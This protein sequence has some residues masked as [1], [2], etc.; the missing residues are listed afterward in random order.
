M[1]VLLRRSAFAGVIAAVLAMAMTLPA[2]SQI[3]GLD[4]LP[5]APPGVIGAIL[6]PLEDVIETITDP[7]GDALGDVPFDNAVRLDANDA[8]EASIALSRITFD[9][10][11]LVMIGRDDVFADSLSSVAS[12]GIAG[13]PLLLTQTD[14]L[15]LRIADELTRLGATE[16]LL[17]GSEDAISPDLESKFVANFGEDNVSRVGGPSRVETAAMLAEHVAPNA[18]TALLMRA[19]PDEGTDQS[20]AYAD[21]LGAGPLG[22]SMEYPALLTTTGYLHPAAEAYFEDSGVEE[23]VIVGGEAA[24]APEVADT[25]TDMGITVTRVAGENRYGTAIEIARFMGFLDAADTSRLILTEAGSVEEP[26]W[27]AGFSAAAHGAV[28]EA[29]VILADGPL[30]PPETIAYLG[31]GLLSNALRLNNLP[32][33]CNSFVDFLACETAALLMLGLLD[34]VNELTGGVL[35]DVLGPVFDQLLD[36]LEGIIP[37]SDGTSPGLLGAILSIIGVDGD[38]E[39]PAGEDGTD[40]DGDGN[41]DDSDADCPDDQS[42]AFASAMAAQPTEVRAAFERVIGTEGNRVST[43]RQ[44]ALIPI[45][46]NLADTLGGP[47]D[48]SDPVRAAA[49]V[50]ILDAIADVLGSQSR[51]VPLDQLN[52]LLTGVET[53][54]D[55]LVEDSAL[56]SLGDLVDILDIDSS[57]TV[58]GLVTEVTGILGGLSGFDSSTRSFT[59]RYGDEAAALEQT[60][61]RLTA[62]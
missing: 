18:D 49:L 4:D 12:Q 44:A 31:D 57:D 28:Y 60:L 47:V 61:E 25:L 10:A 20:Q 27:S 9:S 54:L 34:E 38:E 7:L 62:Q 22:S 56:G 1:S 30:L 46:E 33:I 36:L 55:G 37:G 19:Y 2:Q 15:D 5:V 14:D 40:C 45:F 58:T 51:V 41:T 3:P 6:D 43:S 52:D 39:T 26:L 8:V 17:L 23:V 42:A 24:I 29:P 50:A 59:D 48:T 11:N 16:I 21:A 53:L 35:E 32:L 13:A